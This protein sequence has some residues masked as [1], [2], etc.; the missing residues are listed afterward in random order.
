ML[1]IY[2]NNTKIFSANKDS[3][4]NGQLAKA[5]I[6]LHDVPDGNKPLSKKQQLL[7]RIEIPG[8]VALVTS[9]Y[10]SEQPYKVDDIYLYGMLLR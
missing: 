7:Y 9:Y 3:L 2:Y 5:G 1:N 10:I 4:L 6:N 8:G